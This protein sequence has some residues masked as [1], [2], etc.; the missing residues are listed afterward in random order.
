MRLIHKAKKDDYPEYA[1]IYMK[2]LPDDGLI[3]QHL[4]NHFLMVKTSSAHC[5]KKSYCIVMRKASGASKRYWFI[6]LM[7]S[8]YFHTGPCDL[9]EMKN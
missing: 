4:K 8:G 5:R 1:E 2:L 7:T 3:L 9:Q 6:L